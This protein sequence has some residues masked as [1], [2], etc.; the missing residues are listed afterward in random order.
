MA[1]NTA[2]PPKPRVA[3]AIGAPLPESQQNLP[4]L[5][6]TGRGELA[7]EILALA[8]ANNIK[9]RQDADLAELLGTLALDTPIPPEAI[10]AVAEILNRV[11]EL[12]QQAVPAHVR[13]ALGAAK[14]EKALG[15]SE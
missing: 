5:V 8:F 13:E 10:I 1:H 4:H 15:Q 6:A 7:E 2:P 12:N 9:V 11:Y 3:V 14:I